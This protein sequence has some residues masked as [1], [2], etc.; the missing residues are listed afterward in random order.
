MRRPPA[1]R[2][3]N[4]ALGPVVRGNAER[5]NQSILHC[6]EEMLPLG[7]GS[8][9]EDRDSHQWHAV[10]SCGFV[11]ITLPHAET[12]SGVPDEPLDKDLATQEDVC[13]PSSYRAIEQG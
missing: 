8:A 13:D 11:P 10:R 1:G 9:L 7:S 3:F 2:R 4:D 6:V 5:L 12:I